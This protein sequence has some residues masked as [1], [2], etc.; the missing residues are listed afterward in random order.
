MRGHAHFGRKSQTFG[1][2]VSH[3]IGLIA[4]KFQM[5]CYGFQ[6]NNEHVYQVSLKSETV[7]FNPFGDLTHNDPLT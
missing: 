2:H 4:P 1:G 5:W 7:G 6:N 3:T